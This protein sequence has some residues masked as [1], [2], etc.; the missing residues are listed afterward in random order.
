MM[1]IPRASYVLLSLLLAAGGCSGERPDPDLLTWGLPADLT[2]HRLSQLTELHLAGDVD[3]LDW[4]QPAAH[5]RTLLLDGTRIADSIAIPTSLQRLDAFNQHPFDV[6]GLPAGL[7]ELHLE[8]CAVLGV[9]RIGELPKLRSLTLASPS[10]G[11]EIVFPDTLVSLT[12][13][14]SAIDV[15]TAE[16]PASLRELRIADS[17]ID[18]LGTLPEELTALVLEDTRVHHLRGLPSNLRSLRLRRNQDLD[19]STLPA[20]IV[21]LDLSDQGAVEAAFLSS[22]LSA[23]ALEGTTEIKF[24]GKEP[25]FPSLLEEL[26][27]KAELE[28]R[29]LDVILRANRGLGSLVIDLD[30]APP[31]DGFRFPSN[32]RRL[33]VVHPSPDLVYP[34]RL[35]SL[36]LISVSGTD[37]RFYQDSSKGSNAE[38]PSGRSLRIEASTLTGEGILHALAAFPGTTRL[39]LPQD[40]IADFP[41]LSATTITSLDLSGSDVP[42]LDGLLPA[43]LQE[44]DLS[45][46]KVQRLPELDAVRVLDVSNTGIEDLAALGT[47]PQLEELTLHVGQIPRLGEGFA[48]LRVLRIVRAVPR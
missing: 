24:D 20:L 25:T 8:H 12:L 13:T 26:T 1:K 28:P 32:L 6:G 11:P 21:S 31:D 44:L 5:L 36:A 35:E 15:S 45:F 48:K 17:S 33:T 16:L 30:L 4:L 41:D 7:L 46:S 43:G 40:E 42:D 3:R 22:Q 37:L 19:L 2:P 34:P 10:P 27:V 29:I 39:A 38:P 14:E 23:L 9:E 18:S 47:A